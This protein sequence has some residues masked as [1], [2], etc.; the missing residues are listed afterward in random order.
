[1]KIGLCKGEWYGWWPS[2]GDGDAT[3][4]TTPE[5]TAVV[6]RF[7]AAVAEYENLIERLRWDGRLK[8][9][10][11]LTLCTAEFGT[12]A[13]NAAAEARWAERR[14]EYFQDHCLHWER[15]DRECHRCKKRLS[16]EDDARWEKAEREWHERQATFTAA[17]ARALSLPT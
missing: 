10:P 11:P 4:E 13:E 1:M 14:L 6:E 3:V 5:E 7:N 2:T 15:T 9:D 12:P 8:E 17:T 16:V